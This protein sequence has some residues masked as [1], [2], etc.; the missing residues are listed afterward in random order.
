M[1]KQIIRK[2]IGSAR[3]DM[4]FNT[5]ASSVKYFQE[6]ANEFLEMMLVTESLVRAHVT[7][8]RLPLMPCSS[9]N[10]FKFIIYIYY[11]CIIDN[12]RFLKLN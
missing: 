3:A 8:T 12:T 10:T 5:A 9:M 11:I 4:D 6:L 1:R 2:T 7:R